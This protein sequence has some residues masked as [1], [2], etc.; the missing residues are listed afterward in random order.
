MRSLLALS[1]ACLAA[2]VLPA[3]ADESMPY[4][5]KEMVVGTMIPQPVITG[6]VPFDK[7]YAELSSAQKAAI[8]QDYES[9]ASDDEPPFPAYG[10]SHMTTY[11]TRFADKVKPV[12]QFLAAVDV[13]P[14]G[15]ARGVTVYKSPDPQLTHL[16]STLMANE[17]FKPAKCKGSPCA[18]QYVLRLDFPDRS[19]QHVTSAS[20][21]D[22][23]GGTHG[24]F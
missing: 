5:V 12:G 15:H 2:T 8:A 6:R 1:A 10:L 16:V 22:N 7:T 18:M 3:L 9:L 19:A 11:L 20:R 4:A 17:A 13:S 14:D 24:G 21:L 23:I